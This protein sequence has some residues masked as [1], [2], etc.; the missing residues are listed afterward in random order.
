[1]TNR[2]FPDRAEAGKLLAERLM[3]CAG[4]QDVLV[5]G[6]ARG[7][8]PVAFEIARALAARLDVLV[9][10]KIGLPGQPELAMGA[11]A[12][13]GVRVL[14]TAI[15]RS[16]QISDATVDAVAQAE[17]QELERR[18][19]LYRTG[20]PAAPIRDQ[21]VIVV[22]DGLATGA[23][24]RAALMYLRE[25]QPARLIVAIPVAAPA[26]FAVLRMICDERVSLLTPDPFHSVGF[27]YEDFS[28]TTDAQVQQLLERAAPWQ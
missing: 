5:L 9:V 18:E 19:Q 20:R 1:M 14:N 16:Y 23:T 2:P 6:L 13:A 25:Q 24:M 22:D 3:H 28:Q 21:Q 10:R 12:P 26:V 8:L 15:I 4:R 27:W 11:I 17:L 7:G